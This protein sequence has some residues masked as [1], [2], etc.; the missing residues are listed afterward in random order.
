VSGTLFT[1]G[2]TRSTAEAFFARVE[3][4]EIRVVADVRLERRSQLA[5]FAKQP[6]LAFFLRRLSG[7]DCVDMPQLAPAPAD[8]DAYRRRE[9]SFDAYAAAYLRGLREHAVADRLDAAAF[10]RACLLCSEAG[11]ER[12]H[13]R[14]AAEH[15]AAAWPGPWRVVHL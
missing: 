6:D 10:D 15:L 3:G 1:I 2:F 7:I 11:P 5:G 8:F 13:R 4:A 14:L 12:C 9:L